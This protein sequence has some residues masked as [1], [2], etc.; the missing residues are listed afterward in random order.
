MA[1]L[2]ALYVTFKRSLRSRI[3]VWNGEDMRLRA[4]VVPVV[5]PVNVKRK[6][7]ERLVS[8]TWQEYVRLAVD[9]VVNAMRRYHRP[10]YVS[11]WILPV[12]EDNRVLLVLSKV[13]FGHHTVVEGRGRGRPVWGT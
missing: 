7:L 11:Y 1:T 2:S 4:L 10:Y 12:C 9:P 3:T 13:F 5:V 6:E 8:M